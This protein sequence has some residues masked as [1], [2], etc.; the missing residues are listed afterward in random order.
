MESCFNPEAAVHFN[1]HLVVVF[2]LISHA[3]PT[4]TMF[5]VLNLY[6]ILIG[7]TCV[8]IARCSSIYCPRSC[9]CGGKGKSTFM[10]CNQ[11]NIYIFPLFKDFSPDVAQI[12]L[13]HNKIRYLPPRNG[14]RSK[15]WIIDISENN[16]E[17]IEGN[18]LG[19]MFPK[20]ST[21]D[22]SRNKIQILASDSFIK[23]GELNNLNLENNLIGHIEE[24]VFDNLD[25]LH[26]L[27]LGNNHI[28]ILNLRWFK[29]LYSLNV[30][31]LSHN[32]IKTVVDWK[33]GWPKS[34][35]YVHLNNNSIV[36]IPPIPKHVEIFNLTLNPLHCGCKFETFN[37]GNISN[38]SLCKVSM[39]C[40]IGHGM[41]LNGTC[42]NKATSEKVYNMWTK[43]SKKPNCKKPEIKDLSLVIDGDGTPQITCVASGVPA[44]DVTLEHDKTKQ[45]LTVSGLE[46]SN[47]TIITQTKPVKP[48]L[49]VCKAINIIY[50][51]EYKIKLSSSDIRRHVTHNVE[52]TVH[53]NVTNITQIPVWFNTAN[54]ILPALTGTGK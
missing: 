42:D 30:V 18:Q 23:L 1:T 35:K 31:S 28:T 36:V 10:D 17:S 2:Y 16:I 15:V 6:F 44:P 49:Y 29:E 20:L 50:Q 37:M 32:K 52:A 27:N 14:V 34:L 40:H 4:L 43:L 24:T 9:Y 25:K 53:P 38:K 45:R 11:R 19:R 3:F 33:D 22:L 41:D 51:A 7:Y 5:S 13:K 54:S 47:T 26:N 8:S 46:G 48:G 12:Y 21:L 39:K